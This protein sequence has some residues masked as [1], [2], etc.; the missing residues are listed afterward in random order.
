[1]KPIYN[2]ILLTILFFLLSNVFPIAIPDLLDKEKSITSHHYEFLNINMDPQFCGINFN[3]PWFVIYNDQNAYLLIVSSEG[4]LYLNSSSF[5]ITTS[6][7]QSGWK[8]SFI[9]GN[10]SHIL[11]AINRT[12]GQIY[13]GFVENNNPSITTKNFVVRNASNDINLLVFNSS[14]GKIYLKGTAVYYG[15]QAGCQADGWYCS[16]DIRENRNYYCNAPFGYCTYSV[17]QSENC[18]SYDYYYCSGDYRYLRDYYCSNGA[19]AYSDSSIE[20]CNSYDGCH[21]Y[22]NN[23]GCGSDPAENRDYYCSNGACVYTYSTVNCDTQDICRNVCGGDNKIYSYLDYYVSSSSCSCTYSLGSLVEDCTQKASTDTDGGDYPFTQGTVTDYTGCSGT[24]STCNVYNTYTDYCSSSTTLVEYYP[25]GSSYG[26]KTYNCNNYDGWYCR[27]TEYKEYRDYSCSS[28]GCGYS[29]SQIVSCYS[30][31]NCIGCGDNYY[32][33]RCSDGTCD[34]R[35]V[36]APLT[37]YNCFL[38][39]N[40]P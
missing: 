26:S 29:S 14:D 35:C 17:I 38:T 37:G 1:M 24:S 32:C 18:N 13:G 30:Y 22:G 40:C 5:S 4:N 9:L 25:S 21:N 10:S 27:D 16:G 34:E 3:P 11:F 12:L 15:S 8:N 20:N 33:Y 19:C 23:P 31:D 28:G 6:V 7:Y 2:L 39:A 36:S